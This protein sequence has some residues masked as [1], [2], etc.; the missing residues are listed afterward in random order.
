MERH[1]VRS[2][3]TKRG[4]KNVAVTVYNNNNNNN[5]NDYQKNEGPSAQ[6]S[7]NSVNLNGRSCGCIGT[8]DSRRNF[9]A[10]LKAN[11]NAQES[12]AKFY[13]SVPR[14][15]R[16]TFWVKLARVAQVQAP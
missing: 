9:L 12:S 16:P 3:L 5:N 6:K 4:C 15:G 10:I 7:R 2:G 1:A 8:V 14:P 11:T 13:S